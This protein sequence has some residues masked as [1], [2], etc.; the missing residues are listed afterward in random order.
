M[1]V[2]FLLFSLYMNIIVF[3]IDTANEIILEN[4]EFDKL[5]HIN[6]QFVT[7]FNTRG[8]SNTLKIITG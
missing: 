6:V 1:S 3:F 2:L 8:S 4:L 7:K 5:Y